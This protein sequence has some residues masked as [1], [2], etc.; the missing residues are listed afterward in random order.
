MGMMRGEPT[1]AEV[2][3]RLDES[4]ND[5]QP[6]TRFLSNAFAAGGHSAHEYVDLLFVGAP[7]SEVLRCISEFDAIVKRMGGR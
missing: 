4:W 1:K 3:R 2:L 7:D 5:D 6:L